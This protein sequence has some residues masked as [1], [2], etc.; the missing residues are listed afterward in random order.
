MTFL[1]TYD[2]LALHDFVADLPA[3]WLHRLAVYAR[4]VEFRPGE[5]LF[6][7]DGLAD[8]LWLVHSGVVVLDL[9]VPGRG[10]IEVDRLGADAVLG[11]ETL[12]PPHRW[13]F[14]AVSAEQTYAV[15]F[16]AGGLR[17][18]AGDDP[19]FGREFCVRLLSRVSDSLQVARHRLLRERL[20]PLRAS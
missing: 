7:E 18:F 2:L 3:A 12:I 11:W 19:E 1:S 10:D 15:E 4:P 14:G 8:R 5:R 16:Y 9:H 20:F 17:G 6:R 13:S